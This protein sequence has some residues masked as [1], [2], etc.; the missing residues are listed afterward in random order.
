LRAAPGGA[1]VGVG[2]AFSLILEA[3]PLTPGRRQTVQ[4]VTQSALSEI[5]SLKAARCCQRDSWLALTEAVT[6][7]RRY[8]PISLE[9]N[10]PMNCEQRHRNK[11]CMGT[12]CPLYRQQRESAGNAKILRQTQY[13]VPFE[14]I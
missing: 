4:S 8:L 9:A 12:A 5:S 14:K 3:S 6:L 7:S 13:I 11:E 2:I 10:F 1:A